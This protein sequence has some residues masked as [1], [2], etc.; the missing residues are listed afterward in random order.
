[1]NDVTEFRAPTGMDMNSIASQGYGMVQYGPGD[2][3]LIVG[4][5]KKSILNAARSRAD[6]KPV[7]EG[8]DFVKIQHPGETLNIVD[9]PAHD[10]DRQRWPQKWAQY[11]QGITQRPDGVPLSLLFPDKPQIV[12]MMRGYNIHTVEQLANL[13]GEAISTVG[14]GCQEW[15]NAASRYME[16]V[17]KGVSHHQFEKALS[18]R[19]QT[20]QTLKRQLDE[21]TALVRSQQAPPQPAGY[22]FQTAQINTTH[23][24]NEPYTPAPAQFVHD[25]SGQVQPKRGPG[26]PRK[27]QEH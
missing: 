24:S 10:G 3:K 9:R 26:R 22:D 14:M 27:N 1:M 6:G 20:I 19:D 21:V 17:N 2:D 18:D 12:D 11:Q 5:Y 25:L 4:F 13:S 15:V 8:V 23:Q 16:R 7:Y